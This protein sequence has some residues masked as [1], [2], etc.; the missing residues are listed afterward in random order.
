MS[1]H[2][3][4]GAPWEALRKAVLDRDGW[5]CMTCGK[6]LVDRDAT[7]DHII[8]RVQGG[9]DSMANC[10]AACRRCNGIKSDRALVRLPW[11]NSARLDRL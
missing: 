7:V 3:S 6:P 1:Q 10:I 2:S 4:R 11:F 5:T 9:E 8:P